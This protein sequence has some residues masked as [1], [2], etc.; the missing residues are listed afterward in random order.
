MN[1]PG[2]PIA[3]SHALV[4]IV[5]AAALFGL[6]RLWARGLGSSG[7]DYF[8]FW[9]AGRA[10]RLWPDLDPYTESGR[11]LIPIRLDS[12]TKPSAAYRDARQRRQHLDTKGSPFLYALAGLGATHQYERDFARFQV[13]SNTAFVAGALALGAVAGLGWPVR[14]GLLAFL[15]T[16]NDPLYS[17]AAVGNLNRLQ[18]AAIALILALAVRSHWTAAAVLCGLLGAFKPNLILLMPMLLLAVAGGSAWRDTWPRA[19]RAAGGTAAGIAFALA[20]A[21]LRGFG[22]SSWARWLSDLAAT[23]AQMI[24]FELGNL[25]LVHLAQQRAGIELSFPLF[26]AACAAVAVVVVR[27]GSA[28]AGRAAWP[29]ALA[30]LIPILTSPLAWIHYFVLALPAV[31]LGLSDRTRPAGRLAS[32]LAAAGYSVWPLHSLFSPPGTL[33]VLLF[34]QAATLVVFVVGVTELGR[35]GDKAPLR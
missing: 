9:A 3:S 15:L 13:L 27:G 2:R 28:S 21:H 12:V 6:G 1:V 29:L 17:D 31:Y 18:L 20:F 16:W 14:I 19:L 4:V 24:S 23:P 22:L 7:V 26:V 25:S 34:L 33:R 10:A 5:A 8:Q 30:A 35:C 11:A 32:A